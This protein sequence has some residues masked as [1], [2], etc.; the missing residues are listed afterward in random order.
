MPKRIKYTEQQIEFLRMGYRGLHLDELTAVF[1]KVFGTDKTQGMICSTLRNHGI[2]C[3]LAY[4]YHLFGGK[5]RRF[6][7]EQIDFISAN[8]KG[9]SVAE[10]TD[11]FNAHFGTRMTWRQIRAVVNNRGIVSGRSGRFEKGIRPWNTGTKG[12]MRRNSGTF[13][14]GN[15]PG[16]RKPLGSERICTKNGFVLVKVA[17]KNPYTGSPTRYKHKHVHVW[18]QHHGPVPDGM[19]VAF[20]D[21]DQLNCGPENLMLI[22]RA[23]LL[24]LNHH[25]YKDTPDDLKPSLLALA[26]L[27]TKTFAVARRLRKR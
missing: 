20:R 8:Y 13:K 1:N 7:Q 22:S 23:E 5:G 16:N 6:T 10:M 12:L 27:E 18:E 25:G 14:K 21:G 19:V 2:T 15:A 17:E 11:L 3:D 9:H 24:R 4:K 26:R